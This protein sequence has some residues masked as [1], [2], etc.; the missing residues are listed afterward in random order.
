MELF[1]L[2]YIICGVIGYGA[3]LAFFQKEFYLISKECYSQDV[4]FA[5]FIGVTGPAG[6]LVVAY[7]SCW[8]K[9]GFM[10]KRG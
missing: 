7:K 8:F 6:L 3:T 5:F 1:V 10:W 4:G 9:H 2:F